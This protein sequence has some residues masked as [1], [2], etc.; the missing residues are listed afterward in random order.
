[1]SFSEGQLIFV[2]FFMTIFIV[3]MAI[4]YRKDLRQI[5]YLYKG[6]WKV[7]V[8]II[9]IFSIFYALVKILS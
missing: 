3:A 7:V 2:I 8:A 5:G 6:V 1:M 9:V 4:A